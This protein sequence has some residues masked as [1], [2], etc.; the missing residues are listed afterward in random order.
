MA[1]YHCPGC[2]EGPLVMTVQASMIVTVHGDGKVRVEATGGDSDGFIDLYCEECKIALVN[3][4][5]ETR[6]RKA[7]FYWDLNDAFGFPNEIE[8][9]PPWSPTAT[10]LMSIAEV[11][12]RPWDANGEFTLP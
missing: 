9:P 2:G 11:L 6:L 3:R 4:S 5:G 8:A 7:D 12:C 1:D 10:N